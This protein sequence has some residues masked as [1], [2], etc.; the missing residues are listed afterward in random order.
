LTF[1]AFAFQGRIR[2]LPYLVP[3]SLI[4]LAYFLSMAMS[5]PSTYFSQAIYLVSIFSGFALFYLLF[6][7]F[8]RDPDPRFALQLLL[9]L[10]VLVLLFFAV[11]LTLGFN[12]VSVAGVSEWT[13][14]RNLEGKG[15]LLGPFG[16]AG[17]NAGF[18][19]L[20]SLIAGYAL[21]R[22]QGLWMRLFLVSML[23]AN[24][25]M[26]IATGSRGG[27][28]SLMFGALLFLLAFRRQL[29]A[30]RI[31]GIL[32]AGGAGVVIAALVI[33]TYTPF[34]TLFDRLFNTTFEGIVPDSRKGWFD[35]VRRIPEALT[36]GHGPRIVLEYMSPRFLREVFIG[37]PHNLYL[38]LLYSLGVVGF[39]AWMSW[40]AT[41]A[42][43]WARAARWERTQD[44]ASEFPRLGAVVLLTFLVDSMKIEFLRFQVVDYQH[45]QFT[46]WAIFAAFAVH[47]L[48][49]Y[50]QPVSRQRSA[51]RVTPVGVTDPFAPAAAPVVLAR[52]PG[53]P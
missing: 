42:L 41:L 27:F 24:V 8:R 20:Q 17:P 18:L 19:V 10:N 14:G 48:Q 22:S 16:P 23:F 1:L 44:L 35:V 4:V 3:A 5:I 50:R 49:R 32:T 51:Q 13:I 40:F 29:G 43:H 2:E 34:D 7:H 26:I 39:A 38:F 28:I 47:S 33:I 53:R 30:L 52:G 9:G 31:F 21:M 12:S 15:R 11:Q 25:A 6:N 45:Y 36:F 46:L 37:Y